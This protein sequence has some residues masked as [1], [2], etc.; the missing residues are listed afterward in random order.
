MHEAL[1]GIAGAVVIF[2]M[3]ALFTYWAVGVLRA[4]EVRIAMRAGTRALVVS[5]TAYPKTFWLLVSLYFGAAALTFVLGALLL[6]SLW[7]SNSF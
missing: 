3:A 4:G 7:F 2:G 1:I 6:V 5:R